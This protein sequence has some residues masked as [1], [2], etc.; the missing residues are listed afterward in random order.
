MQPSH[1]QLK[2]IMLLALWQS[3][4][5]SVFLADECVFFVSKKNLVS[6]VFVVFMVLFGD[7]QASY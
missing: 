4:Q 2:K 1:F 7:I 3:A 6:K 5:Q